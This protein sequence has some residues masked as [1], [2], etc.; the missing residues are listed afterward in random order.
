MYISH[1]SP[2]FLNFCTF[3][4]LKGINAL[5]SLIYFMIL[6]LN[7]YTN[8]GETAVLQSVSLSPTLNL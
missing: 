4:S 7:I 6:S 8:L 1:Y 5:A 3:H 2:Y